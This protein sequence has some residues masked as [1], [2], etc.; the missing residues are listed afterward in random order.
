MEIGDTNNDSTY[1]SIEGQLDSIQGPDALRWSHKSFRCSKPRNSD[2]TPIPDGTA[3]STDSTG[4]V[5]LSI[6]RPTPALINPLCNH[7]LMQET[8]EARYSR[9]PFFQVI[10]LSGFREMSISGGNICSKIPRWFSGKFTII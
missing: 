2:G 4:A 10:P 6:G 3:N 8:Q 7:S 1:I 5:V 9:S